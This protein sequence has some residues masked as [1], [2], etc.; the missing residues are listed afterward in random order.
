[1]IIELPE[2][3]D[4]NPKLKLEIL[5]DIA[6]LLYENEVIS[7]GKAARMPEMDRVSFQHELHKRGLSILFNMTDLQKELKTI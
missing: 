6:V 2:Q 7:L 5:L 1:M 3:V 4:L